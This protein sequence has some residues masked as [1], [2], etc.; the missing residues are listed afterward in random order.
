MEINFTGLIPPV[1]DCQELYISRK[2]LEKVRQPL[3][4]NGHVVIY[5]EK[6]Y[7]QHVEAI[8][9]FCNERG[10]DIDHDTELNIVIVSVPEFDITSK[11]K[12][13][14]PPVIEEKTDD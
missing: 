2:I 13:H 4:E 9:S 14:I 7:P 11:M 1:D 10:Y 8:V 3:E 6:W 5:R 12:G